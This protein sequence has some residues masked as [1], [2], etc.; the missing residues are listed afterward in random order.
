M[1]DTRTL[2]AEPGS[3]STAANPNRSTPAPLG[4]S[5]PALT[6]AAKVEV[7]PASAKTGPESDEQRSRRR[8]SSGR[9]SRRSSAERSWNEIG[10]DGLP[11]REPDE[12]PNEEF[13]SVETRPQDVLRLFLAFTVSLLLTQAGLWWVAGVDPLGLA[14]WVSSWAPW[15]VPSGLRP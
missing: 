11:I 15:V 5:P 7:V 13:A 1:T 2:T 9:S 10:V 14:P 4:Q 12:S 6:G 3:E 8:R